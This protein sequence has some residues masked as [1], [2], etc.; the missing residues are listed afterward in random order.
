MVV[1]N[2]ILHHLPFKEAIDEILRVLIPD[3]YVWFSEPN[4]LNPQIFIQKNSEFVKRFVGDSPG[5][6][7]YNRWFI[8]KNLVK[9]GF[10]KVRVTPYEFLHPLTPRSLTK[11]LMLLTDRFE[12][13]PFIKEFAG[14]LEIV[15]QKK[16]K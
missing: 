12:K 3:G 6:K 14:S 11:P 4:Y 13:I 10:V 8:S 2:S 5:E 7:A 15:A 9:R 1:G 16:G